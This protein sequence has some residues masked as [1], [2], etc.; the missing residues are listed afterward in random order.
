MANPGHG[1]DGRANGSAARPPRMPR[2]VKVTGVAGA[3]LLVIAAVVAV[4]SGGEHGPGRHL[5]AA[6]EPGAPA[7]NTDP[8]AALHPPPE[9]A[10]PP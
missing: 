2:W 5:S 4:A 1:E 10:A 9:H 7:A 6:D 8:A 3:G